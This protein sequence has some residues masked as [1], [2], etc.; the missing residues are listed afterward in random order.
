MKRT[1]SFS[2]RSPKLPSDALRKA[3]EVNSLDKFQLVFRQ[4]LESLFIERM[5]LNEE[6]FTD[7]MSK[8]ELQDLV[9]NWLG[10]QVYDRPWWF[11]ISES[12]GMSSGVGPKTQSLSIGRNL[13]R[14]RLRTPILGAQYTMCTGLLE[15]G[16][17]VRITSSLLL[18]TAQPK[19]LQAI[20]RA[21]FFQSNPIHP[22]SWMVILLPWREVSLLRT[23][24]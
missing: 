7:Y 21:G 11:K 14:F 24:N 20:T 22:C 9:S 19:I 16:C 6:L 23:T 8:P 15:T 13:R 2:T 12:A 10:S 5:E 1:S 17:V 4:V 3:A 18:A